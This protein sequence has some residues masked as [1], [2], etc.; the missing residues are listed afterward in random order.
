[1]KSG[2]KEITYWN[3]YQ[4]LILPKTQNWYLDFLINPS[5]QGENRLFVII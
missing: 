2:F 5:F 3:K 4:S 1:M